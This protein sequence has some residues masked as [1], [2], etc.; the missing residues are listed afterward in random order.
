MRDDVR[1][2]SI[3]VLNFWPPSTI[4]SRPALVGGLANLACHLVQP[5]PFQ[6][7]IELTR[8]EA[9]SYGQR[10]LRSSRCKA[11]EGALAGTFV[12]ELARRVWWATIRAGVISLLLLHRS[13]IHR[14][15]KQLAS[16]LKWSRLVQ[17]VGSSNKH[18]ACCKF[19]KFAY[20]LAHATL[21]VRR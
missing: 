4:W 2:H 17:T 8:A 5:F 14:N 9:S 7:A 1:V 19:N 11:G 12:L 6:L 20:N 18:D 13:P 16:L 21:T 15:A 3:N 10:E